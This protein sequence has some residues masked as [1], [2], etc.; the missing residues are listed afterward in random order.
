MKPARDFIGVSF[1]TLGNRVNYSTSQSN[2]FVPRHVSDPQQFNMPLHSLY[3]SR[4]PIHRPTRSEHNL[5]T[6][7]QWEN[8]LRPAH[9]LYLHP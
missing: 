2:G 6:M 8:I 3:I 4:I 1:P 5:W 9:V 7:L